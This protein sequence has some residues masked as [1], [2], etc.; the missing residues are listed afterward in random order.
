[1]AP[2]GCL[3][4]KLGLNFRPDVNR[5]G[6]SRLPASFENASC[7]FNLTPGASSVKLT[8]NI[9]VFRQKSTFRA[10]V[11]NNLRR[12]PPKTRPAVL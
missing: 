2:R 8:G 5:D 12:E 4:S 3:T 10:P 1:V 11:F 7:L 6:H 9:P